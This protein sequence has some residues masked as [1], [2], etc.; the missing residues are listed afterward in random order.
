MN[1]APTQD[2]LV[3]RVEVV[4]GETLVLSCGERQRASKHDLP[5]ELSPS[6]AI[7]ATSMLPCLAVELG[8]ALKR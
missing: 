4:T 3:D 1:R 2:G 5:P 8:L 6:T 7:G